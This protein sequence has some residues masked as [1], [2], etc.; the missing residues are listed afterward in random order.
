MKG[1]CPTGYYE[2]TTDY[3][4]IPCSE[5]FG[6]DCLDCNAEFMWVMLGSISAKSW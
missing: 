1:K 5:T 6:D 3:T 4:C 2:N